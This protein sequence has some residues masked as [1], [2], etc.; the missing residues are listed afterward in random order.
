MGT[1]SWLTLALL[2]VFAPVVTGAATML[3]PKRLIT[4]R[5]G[6]AL[7]GPVVAIVALLQQGVSEEV[8]SLA[9][10][11]T[12]GLDLSFAA[13]QLGMFFALLISGIGC[14]IVVYGRGYFGRDEKSLARFYP[15][16]GLFMTAMMGIVLSDNLLG[17]FMFWELTSVSSF[18]LIG[19]NTQDRT[20][21]KLAM[22]AFAVTGLGGLVMLAGLITL[23]VTSDIWSFSALEAAFDAGTFSLAA[24]MVT[25][26]FALIFVG[27][28]A[29][30][31]QWPLHFWLPG[32]MAAPTPVSAYLHSATMVKAGVYLLA[33]L[34]PVM[35][36]LSW[37]TP[38]LVFFGAIT[39]VVGGYMAIRS[40]VLKKIFA[41]TTVS[42]LGLFVCA[43]GLGGLNYSHGSHGGEHGEAAHG[44][45]TA[46]GDPN[47]IYPITQILNHALYKA[48]LFI[49]AGA[50]M[51]LTGRTVLG[52]LKGL[53]KKHPVLAWT[54]LAAAYAMAGLPFTLSFTA[55]EAFLYQIV[56]GAQQ[57]AVLWFVG[58]AAVFMALCNVAI[59][60]RMARTFFAPAEAHDAHADEHHHA[61]ERGFWGACIWWPAAALV[62]WQFVGGIAPGLFE[63]I[64]GV[65][66]T[67]TG[68]YWATLPGFFYA[69][70]HPSMALGMSAVAIGLG[71]FL[72]F[73]P[74]WSG[75]RK[76]IHDR[77]FPVTLRLGERAGHRLFA[78]VQ[79]GDLRL[80]VM[81]VLMALVSA[82]GYTFLLD[83]EAMLAWPEI[84]SINDV[85]YALAGWLL[86]GLICTSALMLP[87]MKSRV[88]R[89]LILGT[90]GFSVI[91]MYL[92]YQAPDLALTQ[93]MFEIISVVLFLL[94]LRLLPERGAGVR[95]YAL[96]RV[97]FAT[98][99]GVSVGWITLHA[100]SAA[101]Q[102][103]L[104]AWDAAQG[105]P[106]QH[107]MAGET[108]DA[109]IL[110]VADETHSAGGRDARP[111]DARPTDAHP[112]D[113]RPTDANSTE[114]HHAPFVQ[115]DDTRLGGWMLRNSYVGTTPDTH[116]RGGGG[117][118][119]VNVIL[120]D[121]RGY[122]TVGE[123]TV[124]SI[125]M[126]GVLALIGACPAPLGL[127]E[128]GPQK[129]LR[130]YMLRTAMK[131]LLPL[132]LLFAAYVFF[133]GHDRPG[134]GFIAGLIA[135]VGLAAY[136][137]SDGGAALKRLIPI[138]PGITAAI[139]L[140]LA[141]ATGVAPLVIHLFTGEGGPFFTSNNAYVPL[142][143]G[144]TFHW[145]SVMLFDLGVFIVVVAVSVGMINRF[146][147]ELD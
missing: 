135:A 61:P 123:I 92:L 83:K 81:V 4:L 65:V 141:L 22:Q 90:C 35:R 140:A 21:A 114:A 56:H 121:F 86:T 99:V 71:V 115:P 9:F 37:W 113:A 50:I 66:E 48:P 139:G 67:D 78:T 111:T 59:F 95:A 58:A 2:A 38:A 76:D 97:V 129:H 44:A 27:A 127:K 12:L 112:T 144:G 49:L 18:L 98:L 30:S 32:A 8:A 102:S 51:H 16:L 88:V 126:M 68:N 57:H 82:M 43:Y 101:D 125:A 5:V 132:S 117:N 118:N 10:A 53:I 60:V 20:S 145:T 134:G 26:A 107:A 130:S 47:I 24:P 89:V 122:D 23:G 64:I 55:K 143:G 100:G 142:I 45:A 85:D 62:M 75:A 52:E 124:L 33:R 94:A 80:Y 41:Y 108:T 1:E 96:P 106:E 40:E 120:V 19:W 3:F 36:E 14:L 25:T 6:M 29:K 137:M 146:E 72:G 42:Q 104:V 109:S 13:D 31:A 103:A 93:V 84:P 70:T 147:E 79:R 46:I 91:G 119:V 105:A 69:M 128:R 28:M 73:S 138:K 133:K 110:R 136:R 11:P 15:M 131:L 74:I 116:G 34:F 77:L 17:L 63:G 54:S 7:L 87:I 39:M